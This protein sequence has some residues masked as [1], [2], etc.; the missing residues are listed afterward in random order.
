MTRSRSVLLIVSLGMALVLNA[1]RSVQ[2]T[3]TWYTY[4]DAGRVLSTDEVG[5][6]L[7]GQSSQASDAQTK[8]QPEEGRTV[9][10]EVYR[11]A[12]FEGAFM[13]MG[14]DG[15][16][17]YSEVIGLSNGTSAFTVSLADTRYEP[18]PAGDASLWSALA[19]MGT[20]VEVV[21]QLG[22]YQKQPQAQ[23]S[24]YPFRRNMTTGGF[25]RLLSFRLVFGEE[26]GGGAKN[27]RSTYPETSKLASGDWFRFTLVRDGVYRMSY[28]FYRDLT[29]QT[30]TPSDQI[31]IYGSHYGMLPFENSPF[32][33]TDLIPNA[34]EVVDGGDGT[35]GPG[36]HILF[37]ASGPQRWRFQNGRYAHVKNVYSDSASYFLGIGID[38]PYR[39]SNAQ[40]STDNPSHTVTRFNDRQFIDRDLV[41]LIKSGRTAYGEVFDN[42]TTYN[43]NFETPFLVA[44]EPATLVFDGAARTLNS[45]LT[46]N[47][48]T[49]TI[50]SGAALSNTFPVS[51]VGSSYSGDFAREFNQVFNF[52]P[53]GSS[54]PISI[55]FNKFD[56]VTSIGYM[57]YLVLNCRR[58]LRMIGD[59]LHFQDLQSVG[60]GNIAEF[61]MDQS[62]TV[63]RVWEITDPRNVRNVPFNS[64]GQQ[65]SFRMRTDSVRHFIAFRDGGYL[66]PTRVGRVANQDL[67]ATPVG[68]ELVIVCPPAFQSAAQRLADQRVNDGLSV[69]MVSPQQIFNEFSSGAR[70]ATAIKRYM[71][72]LYDRAGQDPMLMPRYLLLFGDGSYNNIS[73]AE[74]NQNWIPSYQTRNSVNFSQ[75]YTSDDYFG[76]L[77]EG[78][79]E[80]PS[81]LVDI[82]VGRLPVSSLQQAREVVDKILN[83][84]RLQLLSSSG[85]VCTVTGD[86]GIA[87]WRTHV[88]FTSDDQDGAGFEGAVHM[89]QSD[90]LARR[91]ENE[92]PCFNVDKIYLDAYQ[93]VS[94][95]GGQ[96]YFQASQDLKDKVQKGTLL[97]NYVG[98]GGEVGWAHER[99]L[100][101]PTILGWT[102]RDRLPLFMTATCEFSRWDDPGRTSAGEFVLLNANGGG[103]ALMTTT[104]LA[105]SDQNFAL[106]QRFYDHAFRTTDSQGRIFNLGDVFRE[107]K[108]AITAQVSPSSVNHRNF[109]LLGDPSQRL[110]MPR[111]QAR[112]MS[113]T[114]TLGNPLDSIKAL[115]TIRI[116]GFIDAGNGQPMADF[117]GLV[118]PTV[119]DKELPQATLANDGGNPF[120]FKIR[121]NIIYR[122]RATVTNGQFSFTFVVPKDINYEFGT[123]RVSCYAESWNLN[124][125]GYT[126]DP[127]VGG[128]ADDIAL[129]EQGPRIELFM[130]D[131]RFVRGGI[132]D[133]NPLIY[134]KL[135]D[136][137]GI[138]T[139]GNSIGHDLLATLNENTDRSIVL[140]DLYEADLDTYKSG[141]VRYRLK[142][143]PEGPHTLRLK[144]WDVFNNSSESTTEFIVASSEELALERVL[145]YPNPFTTYTEFFFEHNRPCTTLNVQVQVFT[146][147][148]RLVKTISRQLA[149]DGFRSEPM[150]WDG[151]DDFG[152]K[153][154]RGVYVYRL[155]VVTPEGEK[156]EKFEKLV[157]LR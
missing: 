69:V 108:R 49:F 150:A 38:P 51:G 110:A 71:R 6:T 58:D 41:N 142:D 82:G 1:Q 11:M 86:G 128:T 154:A 139:V 3:L 39:I 152:D 132:T 135:F 47:S 37:Y 145:N 10:K 45:G 140:N 75:S 144:A 35:F 90:F 155:N 2:R 56:P 77:D 22:W 67:H 114:D 94:T 137:N 44:D 31:N 12:P 143:L 15:L 149:C 151:R 122:G 146:V 157:I 138:N 125:C 60:V 59:Q 78:E 97:V 129:D 117:N 16:P 119:Y 93:Q 4:V 64:D 99:F 120:N 147:S 73:L 33:P 121:K 92:Q 46:S 112:I 43:F 28:E 30:S 91:V 136:E 156:A 25:E 98:H 123:G 68:T 20:D 109:S 14:R 72:M 40:T 36:D 62:P 85:A 52:Q 79:S 131:D 111:A 107:T 116:T 55:T 105:Y 83:Y 19:D 66:T 141:T 50:T 81:E 130:N 113:I 57:N 84:D 53:T 115:S 5:R 18:V 127:I 76:L 134:A 21:S 148:G 80:L 102:N 87:D 48:S 95:P 100:D 7:R 124:A 32:L 42:I 104:R 65:R 70:D 133:E 106:G 96:R 13:D 23:V 9:S 126:N 54:V 61:I 26:Q 88:L 8:D 17:Y 24:I 27:G 153:L 101:N 63:H 29:G 74:T 34:I 103:I 89:S 118:I